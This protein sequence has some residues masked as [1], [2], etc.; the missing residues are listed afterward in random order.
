MGI[1]EEMGYKEGIKEFSGN[2]TVNDG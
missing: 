2:R 1:L